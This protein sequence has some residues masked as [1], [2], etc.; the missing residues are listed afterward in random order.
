MR[1]ALFISVALTSLFT[2]GSSLAADGFCEQVRSFEQK[3]LDVLPD[4]ELQRRWMDFHWAAPENLKKNEVQIGATLECNGSDDVAKKFCAYLIR[5][6]PHEDMTVLPLGV[7]RCHGFV[8]SWGASTHRW[9]QELGWDTP[10]GLIERFQID[11]LDRSDHEPSMR[12]TI[13]PYPESLQAKKPA[14]FFK[15]LSAKLGLEDQ[16]EE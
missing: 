4:G 6:T 11:Q 8:S 3:P 10:N 7:L 15:A 12:L 1:R 16:D 5:N 2:A 9:V 14:P 13:M